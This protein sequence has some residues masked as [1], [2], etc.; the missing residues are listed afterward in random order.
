MFW[1]KALAKYHSA[2]EIRDFAKIARVEFKRN[3]LRSQVKICVIDDDSFRARPNL[4]NY[5][6]QF[7]ELQ[8]IRTVDK[9]R[10]Y[11][12]VICDLMDVGKNFDAAAGGA[13]II[14]E[15]KRNYPT[16]FVIAYSGARSNS[17]EASSAR[18]Y[19]D[20]FLKKDIEISKLVAELDNA[21]DYSLDPYE[22]WT[23][24]R[25]ELIDLEVDLREIL[26]LE[27]AYVSSVLAKDSSLKKFANAVNSASI[28]GHAKAI[29]QSLVASIIYEI[30]FKS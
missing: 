21:I 11:E 5:G 29:S 12:V 28:T 1:P 8:D 27:D 7:D 6:F 25:Q 13:S 16:K 10:P 9:V 14:S 30:L 20:R 23:V 3:E 17:Q 19:A 4:E 18:D 26:K 2:L 22:K 24:T 15:I